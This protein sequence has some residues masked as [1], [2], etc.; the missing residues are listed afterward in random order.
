[1]GKEWINTKETGQLYIEKI[2]VTFDVPILFVCTDYENRKYLCLN[3]DEDDKKYV[4]ART[5]NQNLI[6]MLTNMISMESVFRTSKDDNV[7]IAE[8]DDESESIITTV[9]DSSHISKDFLPEVGAYFELSNKMILDYIEYLKRQ[10]IKVTTE[11]FWKMTYKIEQNNC[12]LNFDI[13]DE[14]T[15]NLKLMF[16]ANP[17]DNYL[18]DIKNDSKMVA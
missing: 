15:K 8:Y 2:L 5:D 12:S 11:D 3:A 16:A 13:V 10:I 4:I 7:I 6:K 14:Y 17:K 1:M 9:D 18:Y